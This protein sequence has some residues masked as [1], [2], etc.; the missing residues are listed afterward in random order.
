MRRRSDLGLAEA[1]VAPCDETERIVAAVFAELLELDQVGVDDELFA[2]GGDSF[3]ALRIALT[4]EARLPAS[5]DAGQVAD[6]GTVRRLCATLR[7]AG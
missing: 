3:V 6:C 7:G 4:L 5:L 1:A 2:L